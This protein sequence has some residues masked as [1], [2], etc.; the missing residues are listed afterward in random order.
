MIN[1]RDTNKLKS[2]KKRIS[3]IKVVNNSY[4]R[5]NNNQ[6]KNE[7]NS[8][9]SFLNSMKN[10][11]KLGNLSFD[12]KK[13]HLLKN[14]YKVIL[15]I[16]TKIKKIKKSRLISLNNYY[17][18]TLRNDLMHKEFFTNESINKKKNLSK[19]ERKVT[20]QKIYMIKSSFNN[21]SN[22][23]KIMNTERTSSTNE[24]TKD[25]T[26]VNLSNNS[27]VVNFNKYNIFSCK[28]S[29]IN[30]IQTYS[31][32]KEN[33]NIALSDYKTYRF[34]NLQEGYTNLPS[35]KSGSNFFV[36]EIKNLSRERYMNQCLKG[37]EKK[38]L[39]NRQ[40]NDDN[41]KI[42][43]KKK[44]DH[45]K[46]FEIFNKDYNTYYHKL[47]MQTLKG[48]DY[49]SL[50]KLQI[51]TYKNE[52]NRLN[53]K[54][55]KLLGKLNKYIKMKHFLIKMRNYSLD[56]QEY[57]N[58]MFGRSHKN[59]VTD[60]GQ[61]LIKENRRIKDEDPSI[62]YK[63]LK[64]QGSLNVNM[65]SK[66]NDIIIKLESDT[67]NKKYRKQKRVGSVREKNPLLGSAIKEISV[68]LNNHI[69][70]LLIYQNDLRNDLEPLK[71][72][73]YKEF[74]ALKKNEEKQNELLKL[75]FLILPEKKRILKDRNDFLTNTLVNINNNLF[76][77]SKYNR[78]NEIIH[79][80]LNKI[81]NT[82]LSN[83]II[84]FTPMKNTIEDKIVEKILYY[85]RNIE[86]GINA[87]NKSKQILNNKYPE[88]LNEVA[89][90]IKEELKIKK[91]KKQRQMKFIA[92]KKKKEKIA[93]NMEKSLILN[94]KK[95]YYQYG[96]KK[97]K[98][99]KTYVK[100]DPYEELIYSDDQDSNNGK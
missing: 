83:K 82:L 95:D 15:P 94:R 19:E 24:L 68:I 88:V 71:K 8:S 49:T 1:E 5:K 48:S 11:I 31:Y 62:N 4:T 47:Q 13:L 52:V 23:N 91:L 79:N 37:E 73:F 86:K 7:E 38:F 67:N 45:K 39:I 20:P 10:P 60:Y 61:N 56:K 2:I 29:I 22:R 6:S 63:K 25:L 92:L 69:A 90:E 72:E 27:R 97:V 30:P 64:R 26:N 76:N 89:L 74:T 81:Y 77:S 87:L 65:K 75:Q 96:Y 14:P 42:E 58:W 34:L 3:K 40:S 36:Y 54:K 21:S 18:R 59:D 46:L 35:I 84:D 57:D 55:D 43:M 85:L 32:S 78:M 17:K 9:S 99:K 53:I 16:K 41:Y 51:Y 66:F 93:K 33:A 28:N 12:S 98:K 100:V 44:L 80:K 70:N 50:L